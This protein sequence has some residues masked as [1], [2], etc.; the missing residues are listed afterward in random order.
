M[1]GKRIVYADGQVK[2]SS[3]MTMKDCDGESG[4]FSLIDFGQY[5][6]HLHT[7]NLEQIN[8]DS[9]QLGIDAKRSFSFNRRNHFQS[10]YV[11]LLQC[12]AMTLL[13]RARRCCVTINMACV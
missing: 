12:Q 9:F 5:Y 7:C 4:E 8:F 10:S 3:C 11:F 2:L 6:Y 13:A 1:V